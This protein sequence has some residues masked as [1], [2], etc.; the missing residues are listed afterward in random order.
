MFE[1]NY[2][3]FISDFG[4]KLKFIL[5][6]EKVIDTDSQ[7]SDLL[8]IFDLSHTDSS[9][10]Y[11]A[12]KNSRP[13]LT[14]VYNDVKNVARNSQVEIEGIEEKYKVFSIDNDGTGFAIIE[15]TR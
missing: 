3:E 6:C 2:S 9:V 15:L 7:G 13:R 8:G 11:Q 1:E 14:C 4:R 5:P 10:G 12:V